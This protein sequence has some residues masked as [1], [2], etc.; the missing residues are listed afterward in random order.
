MA[1]LH[2]LLPVSYRVIWN[3]V[4]QAELPNNNKIAL[5]FHSSIFRQ[6]SLIHFS[7]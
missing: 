5:K 2:N 6:Y 1:Y 7:P 4:H 3:H